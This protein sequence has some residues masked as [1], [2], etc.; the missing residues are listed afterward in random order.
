[1]HLDFWFDI[2]CPY[3]YLGSTQIDALAAEHGATV[4]WRPMLLGGV[5]RSIGAPDT[6][7]MPENKARL[8]RLDMLRWANW[9]QVPLNPNPAHPR[10]SVLA[11]RAV[12]AAGESVDN[13]VRR[14]ARALFLAYHVEEQ[15]IA[16]PAVVEAAL[17]TAGLEGEALVAAAGTDPI[18]RALREATDEA[19]SLG[20]FGAPSFV[21][22]DTLIWGQDRLDFVADALSG[23]TLSPVVAGEILS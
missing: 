10:R 3:A 18:K 14:A 4:T 11:N 5:F 13:G 7:A 22:G 16:D 21:I 23:L 2:V 1:M 15:D 9:F 20:I 8:N 6:P 17:N 19:V 12:I